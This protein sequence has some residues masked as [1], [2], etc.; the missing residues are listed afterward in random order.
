M[1][2]ELEALNA[3]REVKSHSVPDHIKMPGFN[4]TLTDLGRQ[5]VQQFIFYF[6]FY[7]SFQVMSGR[8]HLDV[9]HWSDP[10]FEDPVRMD[11][12]YPLVSPLVKLSHL[13]AQVNF[14]QSLP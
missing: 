2:Y 5:Q 4:A 1:T 14:F 11:E 12:F 7:S 13:S 3:E 6:P 10:D 9:A 8:F